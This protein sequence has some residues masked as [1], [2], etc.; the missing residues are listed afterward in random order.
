V[1]VTIGRNVLGVPMSAARWS[2][3]R[4]DASA[5]V[6]WFTFGSDG[7]RNNAVGRV[8]RFGSLASPWV[9]EFEESV[10][11][12]AFGSVADDDLVLALGWLAAEYSQESLGLFGG[13]VSV[14]VGPG[15]RGPLSGYMS[16]P[17]LLGRVL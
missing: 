4:S 10:A 13:A 8:A 17:D 9:D 7:V 15:D 1:V 16:L 3:F 11:F 14:L 2:Q 5:V 12:F 6:G